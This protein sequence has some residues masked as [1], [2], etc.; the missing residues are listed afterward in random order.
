MV[1]LDI[2]MLCISAMDHARKSKFSSYVHLLYIYK[3]NVSISLYLNDAVQCREVIIFEHIHVYLITPRGEE[4]FIFYKNNS[5][6][7]DGS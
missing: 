3:Q 2:M 6:I 5:E 4:L 1:T 7:L